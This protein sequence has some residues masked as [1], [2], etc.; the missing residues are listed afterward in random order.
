MSHRQVPLPRHPK[1][2]DRRACT[3]CSHRNDVFWLRLVIN[4]LIQA[5][6]DAVHIFHG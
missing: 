3:R 1:E 6:L 4:A 2:C 5:A